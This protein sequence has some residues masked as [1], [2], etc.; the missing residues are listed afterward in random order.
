M[1]IDPH[2]QPDTV[3]LILDGRLG[4]VERAEVTRHLADCPV[5]RMEVAEVDRAI[6]RVPVRRWQAAGWLAAAAVVLAVAIPRLVPGFGPDSPDL[7]RGAPG[8][9][10]AALP[11]YRPLGDPTRPD[12]LVWGS[13]GLG[14]SYQITVVDRV[15]SLLWQSETEDTV[16]RFPAGLRLPAEGRVFWSVDALQRDG[17]LRTTGPIGL[18]GAR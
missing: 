4:R 5:C 10:V 9:G 2:L 7:E 18:I 15:G 13:A 3:A 1:T 6:Q 11:A 12:G 14:T 17:S 16:V 8:A